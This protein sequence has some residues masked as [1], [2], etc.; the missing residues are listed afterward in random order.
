MHLIIWI[1]ITTPHDIADVFITDLIHSQTLPFS[2]CYI[3]TVQICIQSSRN[4]LK[5]NNLCISWQMYIVIAI[6]CFAGA[7]K[8]EL[9]IGNIKINYK[10][11]LFCCVWNLPPTGRWSYD[12]KNDSYDSSNIS[13]KLRACK[14]FQYIKETW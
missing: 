1:I 6:Y 5:L 9:Q 14:H 12:P 13:S 8:I 7:W 3:I 11:H 10:E 2:I 4:T